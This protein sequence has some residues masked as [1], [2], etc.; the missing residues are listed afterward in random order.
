MFNDKCRKNHSRSLTDVVL[1]V[2][3]ASSILFWKHIQ[4]QGFLD[5]GEVVAFG[6]KDGPIPHLLG[7]ETHHHLE[8]A[9]H[10]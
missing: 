5:L 8:N 9:L 3:I 2:A 1:Q 4:S 6:M 10:E 7:H